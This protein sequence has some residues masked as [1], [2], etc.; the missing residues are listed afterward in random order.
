MGWGSELHSPATQ[1]GPYMRVRAQ[2]PCLV[3]QEPSLRATAL[4]QDS[5]FY[6][7]EPS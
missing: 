1:R 7:T 3:E 2:A 4:H 6:W 5:S